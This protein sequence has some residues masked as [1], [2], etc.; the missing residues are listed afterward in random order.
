MMTRISRDESHQKLLGVI[1]ALMNGTPQDWRSVARACG[2]Q[3]AAADRRLRLIATHIPGV[4]REDDNRGRLVRLVFEPGRTARLELPIAYAACLA[5]SV[6][7]MFKGTKQ[8]Q[9]VRTVRSALLGRS[10]DVKDAGDELDRKFLFVARGGELAFP[11]LAEDLEDVL[12]A[13][14]Q[15]RRI[16]FD[17][18]HFDG[19]AEEGV[20]A[21]PLSLAIHEHQFYLLARRLGG[22]PY[23]FR[24]A[25]IGTESVKIE[26]QFVYPTRAEYDPEQLL[27][28]S[29]GIFVTEDFPTMKVKVHLSKNWRLYAET[30]R[31]HSSQRTEPKEDGVLVH[32]F[33]RLCPELERWVLGFGDDALVL[34]PAE[35]RERVA[36]RLAN[37]AVAYGG[38]PAALPRG[39]RP[40]VA[41][42]RTQ[43]PKGS[44]RRNK[45][46]R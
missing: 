3:R 20:V 15:N 39:G 2:V 8:E 42:A 31:W 9:H 41:A 17:Y 5:A 10:D 38:V 43:K 46:R 23:P 27:R 4:H 18:Q 34:E 16:R 29:I 21:E 40:G 26:D 13:L 36:R 45:T 25:R 14:I 35:L 22:S 6:S 24:F 7:A 19:R 12:Q 30:H 33:V 1:K 28:E 44:G 11:R 37:A 32:L